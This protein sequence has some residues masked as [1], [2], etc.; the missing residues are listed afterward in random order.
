MNIDYSRQ[1]IEAAG[2]LSI[3]DI[4]TLQCIIE[5]MK[6]ADHISDVPDCKLLAGLQK[7]YRISTPHFRLIILFQQSQ[8][9][10][11]IQL[12]L[13]VEEVL[14]KEQKIK[15]R[16]L[17]LMQSKQ[18]FAQNIGMILKKMLD[19]TKKVFSAIHLFYAK[20]PRIQI[21]I[22]PGPKKKV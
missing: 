12:L 16:R 6:K 15:S 21:K 11:F 19:F 5:A 20:L 4:D 2:K 22:V 8:G 9:S 14:E 17:A 18:N 3:S 1:F 10:A 7:M 13:P